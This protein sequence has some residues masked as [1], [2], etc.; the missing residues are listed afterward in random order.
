MLSS[1]G[2]DSSFRNRRT[3]GSTSWLVR[4]AAFLIAALLFLLLP[5]PSHPAPAAAPGA[6][7]EATAEILVATIHFVDPA[8]NSLTLLTGRGH[9]LRIV[10]VLLPAGLVIQRKG[11]PVPRSALKPGVVVRVGFASEEVHG[12]RKAATVELQEAVP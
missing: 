6:S 10:Q 12:V 1:S 9:A 5:R 2:S 4:P 7:A 8:S 3:A 11:A